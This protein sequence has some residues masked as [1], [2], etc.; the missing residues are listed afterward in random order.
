MNIVFFFLQFYTLYDRETGKIRGKTSAKN[1]TNSKYHLTSFLAEEDKL[2]FE[3][4]EVVRIRANEKFSK[5]YEC[6]DEIGE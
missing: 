3:I 1:V 2:P 6:F 4:K 5:Y